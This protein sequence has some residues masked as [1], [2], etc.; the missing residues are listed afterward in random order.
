M[1][2]MMKATIAITPITL[3]SAMLVAETPPAERAVVLEIAT[4][5]T[6]SK[7]PATTKPTTNKTIF[8]ISNFITFFLYKEISF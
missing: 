5:P 1:I 8:S 6:G 2:I 4:I 3:Y 7:T